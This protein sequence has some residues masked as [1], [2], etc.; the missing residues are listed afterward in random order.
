MRKTIK[1]VRCR[2][3]KRRNC[4]KILVVGRRNAKNGES[5][6]LSVD[7]TQ[8]L[9]KNTRRRSTK[10]RICQKA[11]VIR[12]WKRKR[13]KKRLSSVDESEKTAKSI[14]HPRMK[15]KIYQKT[16][17]IRGWNA[18]NAKNCPSSMDE[19]GKTAKSRINENNPRLRSNALVSRKHFDRKD[20]EQGVAY[21]CPY[22]HFPTHADVFSRVDKFESTGFN[23]SNNTRQMFFLC[24]DKALLITAQRTCI[25][26]GC[27]IFSLFRAMYL[28]IRDG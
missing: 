15:V 10:C 24:V 9:L 7:E 20:I 12:G 3:T 28:A 2:P 17:I 27:Y 23:F 6:P 1:T 16:L 5:S 13:G 22:A 19:S 14:H 18:E 11:L 8:N 21:Q 25:Y 26:N 4:K